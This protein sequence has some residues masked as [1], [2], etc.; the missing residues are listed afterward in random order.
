MNKYIFMLQDQYV[1]SMWN[2]AR[3]NNVFFHY[4]KTSKNTRS[5]LISSC[6]TFEY[7]FEGIMSDDTYL[8][9]RLAIPVEKSQCIQLGYYK[10]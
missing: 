4:V 7:T 1:E 8:A 5:A 3:H 9:F 6:F 2:F 10:E